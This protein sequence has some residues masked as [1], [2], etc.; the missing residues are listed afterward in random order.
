MDRYDRKQKCEKV[1]GGIL[2][3]GI[4]QKKIFWSFQKYTI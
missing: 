2:E 1:N 4:K 3:R